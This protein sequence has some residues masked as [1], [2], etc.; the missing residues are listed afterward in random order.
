MNWNW[1]IFLPVI[2]A[3]FLNFGCGTAEA[4]GGYLSGYEE[5]E[6]KP[7]AVSWWSTLAYL[8]SLVAVFAVVVVM[9]YFTAKFIGGRFNARMSTGGGR[10]LENLPLGPNRSVCIVEMAGRV[11]LLGVGENVTLLSEITD[12]DTIENLREKNRAANDIFYQDFGSVSELIQKIPPIFKK[13]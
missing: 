7:T 8:L 1:K 9:A 2:I 10:V 3:L 4:V 5:V 11:F 13:K 6:P 12:G